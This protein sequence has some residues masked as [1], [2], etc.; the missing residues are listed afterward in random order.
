MKVLSKI[1]IVFCLLPTIVLADTTMTVDNE[2][3]LAEESKSVIMIEASTGEI[4]FEKESDIKLA[5]ASMTKMMSL[6]LIMEAIESNQIKLD[7]IVTVSENAS[8]MGGSQILLETNEQMSVDDLIKGISIA[9]GN[10]ATVALAEFIAGSEEEFVNMMNEKAKE[11][12]LKNTNFVNC[13]GLDAVNHYSTASDMSLIAKELVDHE[14]VLEYSSIYEDYL[15]EDTDRKIWLVN[16]NKLVR[17]YDGVD[18]LKT[19]YTEEAGYCLTSTAEKNGMRLI[20]VIMGSPSSEVRNAET[21]E[22]LNY[23]FNNYKIQTLISSSEVL[24]KILIDK[25]TEKYVD[26]KPVDDVNVVIKKNEKELVSNYEINID[27]IDAPVKTGETV[28]EMIVKVEGYDDMK[29]YLTVTD[30]VEKANI[31]QLFTNTIGDI[32]KGS[33]FF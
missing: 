20:T 29:M 8:S 30:D 3:S 21:T 27:A 26:I 32:F 12:N 31:L 7:D 19:G 25:G 24:G 28:G 5:P 18:G 2:V 16:T 15:R 4:L 14:K 11:L 6:L 9:S 23:G 17:F 10:D 1:L 22:L 13:H 33:L